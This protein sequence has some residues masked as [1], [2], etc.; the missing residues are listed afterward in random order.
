M[1]F[2]VAGAIKAG[3]TPDQIAQFLAEKQGFDLDGALGAGASVDQVIGFLAKPAEKAERS[4]GQAAKDTVVQL[5][6]GVNTIAGAVPNLVAPDSRAAEF[7]NR[8]AEYWRDAQSDP[9][10]QRMAA[11]DREISR[12]GE[13]GV[14]SQISEAA[15][16]YASD[17]SLAA[18]L[19]RPMR[20][21]LSLASGLPS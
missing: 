7:F 6:E 9:M 1:Q 20:P 4:W 5:A 18:R 21:V 11:A 3:A 16:Q 15:S 10:K 17:P 19:S 13:D 8:N 14:L 2:D 12:A